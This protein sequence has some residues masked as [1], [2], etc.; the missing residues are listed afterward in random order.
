M[1]E[2]AVPETL[3]YPFESEERLMNKGQVLESKEIHTP[4]FLLMA[5]LTIGDSL[6][7]SQHTGVR[8]Q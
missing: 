5:I 8:H 7:Y 1:D 2:S 4:N 3:E 6:S